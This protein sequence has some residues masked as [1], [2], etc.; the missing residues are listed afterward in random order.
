M[1]RTLHFIVVAAFSLCAIPFVAGIHTV[2]TTREKPRSELFMRETARVITLATQTIRYSTS[3]SN[4][5][6]VSLQRHSKTMV[7]TSARY[8]L[9]HSST[10]RGPPNTACSDDFMSGLFLYCKI[11]AQEYYLRIANNKNT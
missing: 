11:A 1:K 10:D 6:Y 4:Q 5:Q 3:Y 7:L 8:W 2:T 9:I